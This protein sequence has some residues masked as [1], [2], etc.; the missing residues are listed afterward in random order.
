MFFFEVAKQQS[1]RA[2]ARSLELT[3]GAISQAISS[4]EKR[5]GRS[6]FHR[7]TRKVALTEDGQAFLNETLSA[8][9][10]IGSAVKTFKENGGT[11]TG[12]LRLIVEPV[13]ATHVIETILPVLRS[14]WPDISVEVAVEDV[15]TNFISS[16]FDAGIRI[17]SYIA[18]DMIAIKVSKKFKWIILG[19]PSYFKKYGK[20]VTPND[21]LKHQCLG[22]RRLEKS[23]VYHWELVDGNKTI[24]INPGRRVVVNNGRLMRRLAARGMG[25]IYTSMLHASE[26]L[27]SG[28]L[29][30]VLQ[31]Y[32]PTNA[33]SLYLYFT[34]TNRNQPKLRALIECCKSLHSI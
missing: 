7:T 32:M 15:H 8:A 31:S 24:R 19:A 34:K 23:D 20:P 28:E 10:K 3:P 22:L 30:P 11:V 33:E 5:L 18:P 29:V 26:E 6:L 9:E 13:A 14:Q 21:L 2:A 27:E 1:F 17:G 4:L 16:G 12:T 25:L